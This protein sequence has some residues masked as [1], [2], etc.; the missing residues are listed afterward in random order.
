MR[1]SVLYEDILVKISV[2]GASP[3]AA[4]EMLQKINE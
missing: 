3:E 4:F 1:F 2:K